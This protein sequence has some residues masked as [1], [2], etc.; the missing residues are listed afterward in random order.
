[1]NLEQIIKELNL[2]ILTEQKDFSAVIPESGYTSDLLSCVMSGAKHHGLWVT[3]QAHGNI[4]AVAAL[5]DLSAVI[6]TEGAMPD[7]AAV[8]K[9]N[10]E[11][12]ILLATEKPSFYIVGQLWKM[13]V[14]EG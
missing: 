11:G 13:G 6:I 12:V 2:T 10:R 14:R 3:L 9:A 1:M 8:E 4:V 7:T 5:L